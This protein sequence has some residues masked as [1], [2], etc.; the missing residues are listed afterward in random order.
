MW[1]KGGSKIFRSYKKL[2]KQLL[3]QKEKL[4]HELILNEEFGMEIPFAEGISSGELSQYDN[5]PADSGTA[6][7]EREKDFVLDRM[8]HEELHDIVTAINK[9]ENGTYGIDEETGE[10]I[11]Y[12]RLKALPTARTI[13][14]NSPNQNKNHERPIEEDVLR[15]MEEDYA[16]NSE[17]TEYNEQN[18]YQVVASFN[19]TDMT[20]EGSSLIDNEDGMGYVSLVEGFAATGM[21]GFHGADSVQFVR[22][23]QYDKWMNQENVAEDDDEDYDNENENDYGSEYGS[24]YDSGY[25]N[26]YG[27]E[28]DF[29]TVR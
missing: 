22:N 1:V 16:T 9:I 6:L 15:E 29:G 11:P 7:Y 27:D 23:I 2:K 24:E 25:K 8:K 17:E 14:K 4:E 12:A 18:A 5:H 21:D 19:E 3:K 10:K 28:D 13:K 26:E 20:Y